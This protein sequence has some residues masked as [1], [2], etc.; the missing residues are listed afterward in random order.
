[1]RDDLGRCTAA[2]AAY[3]EDGQR[4]AG[5]TQG[6]GHSWGYQVELCESLRHSHGE[7]NIGPVFFYFPTGWTLVTELHGNPWHVAHGRSIDLGRASVIM[8][9]VNVTPDSFSDGGRFEAVDAA[10]AHALACV[11]EGA[12][13]VDIGGESTRPAAEPV[14][15][16]EEQRRILPVIEALRA[17]TA[18]LISVDSYRAETARLAIGA[19]AHIINDVFGLQRE[20]EL[21]GLAA[22]TGAGL[23]IMHTGRDRQ[24]LSDVIE[25]QF[26]FLER[27]LEIAD[28]AQVSRESIVLDPGFGFAKNS[29]EDLE[30]LACFDALQRLGLPLLVGTSRK[31]F[32]GTLTGRD[33]ADR[34]VG[35]AATSVIL[36]LQ[37]A[38]IFRVHNVAINRDALAVADAIVATRTN[39]REEAS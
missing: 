32:I 29:G 8:A 37:G 20:P 15:A 17:K 1:V 35:T 30:L 6:K 13:I 38:A 22:E 25:D 27:S 19:G 7:R 14:T 12:A 5:M 4:Q 9:I 39:L 3:Q 11:A 18:A 36:R 16:A 10:V 21:A 33:A 31:R 26:V 28:A 2:H 24:K 34:D 23:C